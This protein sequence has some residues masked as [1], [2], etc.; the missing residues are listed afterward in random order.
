MYG[1]G[2]QVKKKKKNL[3]T[4]IPFPDCVNKSQF[5]YLDQFLLSASA[6]KLYVHQI[7]GLES[8]QTHQGS[9]SDTA[10]QKNPDDFWFKLAKTFPL[11]GNII[12]R[13]GT[14]VIRNNA[15]GLNNIDFNMICIFQDVS[16]SPHSPPQTSFTLTL[17]YVLAQ[18][19]LS[20]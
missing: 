18:I 6:N 9:V 1:G 16:N 14:I 7:G 13:F 10:Q 19:A 20:A 5:Y 2:I 15:G 11:P 8:Q 17:Y 12:A 3:E 4:A